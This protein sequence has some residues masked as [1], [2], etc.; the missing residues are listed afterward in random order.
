[1]TQDTDPQAGNWR[2]LE[3][4]LVLAALLMLSLTLWALAG[5]TISAAVGDFLNPPTPIPTRVRPTRPPSGWY[6]APDGGVE[7]SLHDWELVLGEIGYA[8]RDTA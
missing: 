2:P 4:L 7:V 3:W 5:D 8:G 1:M 6:V